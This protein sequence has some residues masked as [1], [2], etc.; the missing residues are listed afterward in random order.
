M[1]QRDWVSKTLAGA[2]LGLTLAF[3]CSAVFAH[4]AAGLAP[5]LRAQ[6]AMWLVMP[7]WLTV[8]SCVYLFR[9]GKR[10]WLWLGIVNIAVAG[11]LAIARFNA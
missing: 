8:F 3:A 9:S 4:L 11:I 2:L 5:P 10:A 7:V 6:L 1:I